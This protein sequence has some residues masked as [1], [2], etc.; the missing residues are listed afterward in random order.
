MISV[1]SSW[2]PLII[3]FLAAIGSGLKDFKFGHQEN[4]RQRVYSILLLTFLILGAFCSFWLTHTSDEQS[5]KIEQLNR[6][7]VQQNKD[8][9]R[10]L[11]ITKGELART[12]AEL[13]KRTD[14]LLT[15]SGKIEQLNDFILSSITGGDSYCYVRS[16]LDMSGFVN[17]SLE[18]IGKFPL[19]NVGVVIHDLA[20]R[21]EL[22]KVVGLPVQGSLTRVQLDELQKER[23]LIGESLSLL[24]K[25]VIF[26]HNWPSFP[27]GSI[28]IPFFRTKLPVNNEEQQYL[29]KISASNGTTTQ[30]IRLRKIKGEWKTSTRV[31]KYDNLK[32]KF[33]EL[34]SEIDPDVPLKAYAGE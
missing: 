10:E 12:K 33:M 16:S 32:L 6:Q 2:I 26:R 5:K 1:L 4:R 8:L 25:D 21:S 27:P 13:Y 24:E 20:K 29:V 19:H 30:P 9:N 15:K 7:I 34:R 31:Q 11:L 3:I 14:D 18:H 22:A 23:D 28:I 17:F